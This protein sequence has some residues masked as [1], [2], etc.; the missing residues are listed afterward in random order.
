MHGRAG[1]PQAQHHRRFG[2]RPSADG[3]RFDSRYWITFNSEIYDYIELR[4]ELR[5]LGHQF[6]T[7]SDTEVILASYLQWQASASPASTATGRS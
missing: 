7:E 1:T 5:S 4:D 6:H 2:K 3:D